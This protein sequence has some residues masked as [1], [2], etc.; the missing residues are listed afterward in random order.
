M[1]TDICASQQAVLGLLGKNLFG[2]EYELPENTDAAALL[3]ECSRQSVAAVALNDLTLPEDAPR[4]QLLYQTVVNNNAV[5]NDHALLH[6]L[7]EKNRIPYVVL[8]GA[9]SAFYYPDPLLRTM[10]DVDFL[11]KPEDMDRAAAL[12]LSEGYTEEGQGGGLH[13]SFRRGKIHLELHR[14]FAEAINPEIDRRIGAYL[15][16]IIDNAQLVTTGFCTCRIPD[17][18]CHGLVLL[19]HMQRHM[20]F[21][22]LGLRH[23]CDWAVFVNSFRENEFAALFREKLEAVG[24]WKYAQAV[25]LAS[26]LGLGLPY[27]AFMGDDR[28]TAEE[29]LRDILTSGNFGANDPGRVN[30]R[31]FLVRR[32]VV[33]KESGSLGAFCHQV[34]ASIVS[35]WPRAKENALLRLLGW[36]YFPF[37]RLALRMAG[38]R[39]ALSLAKSYKKSASRKSLYDKLQ[40]FEIGEDE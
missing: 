40:L 25:S 36:V 11:V 27:A 17:P 34:N 5:Y 28:A 38:K 1:I 7:M 29:L 16:P 15:A 32:S 26:H 33:G 3:D 10:G 6:K 21:E 8:K 39:N 31:Y 30:E 2:R 19:L 4:I 22:G 12:L 14:R 9:A 13:R 35:H 24:L 20:L 23:L 18:F 37:Y